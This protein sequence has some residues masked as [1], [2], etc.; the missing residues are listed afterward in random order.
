MVS[1]ILFNIL[2]GD[3]ESNKIAARVFLTS[4]ISGAS[5]L[6]ISFFKES[7]LR[8]HWVFDSFVLSFSLIFLLSVSLAAL[9]GADYVIDFVIRNKFLIILF[10]MNLLFFKEL[11]MMKIKK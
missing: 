8:H 6:F 5:L 10:F 1:F 7:A 11:H 9:L 3:L 2:G 4:L